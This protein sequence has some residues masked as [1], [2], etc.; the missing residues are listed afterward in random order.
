MEQYKFNNA[1]DV[2]EKKNLLR[3]QGF[4]VSKIF[5][6]RSSKNATI[7]YV[8]YIGSKRNKF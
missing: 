4:T 6:M 2:L 8:F 3:K 5:K 1:K 7:K